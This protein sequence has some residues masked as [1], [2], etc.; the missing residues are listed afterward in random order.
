MR[1]AAEVEKEMWWPVERWAR[2]QAMKDARRIEQE[3]QRLMVDGWSLRD[4]VVVTYNGYSRVEVNER[5]LL[6][7]SPI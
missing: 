1:L 3:A 5:L 2:A 4:L 6:E 7:E